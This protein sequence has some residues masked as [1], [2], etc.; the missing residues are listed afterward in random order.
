VGVVLLY[1]VA[2]AITLGG[3]G[4]LTIRQLLGVHTRFLMSGGTATIPAETSALVI[5]LLHAL[6]G[7]LIG[8]GVASLALTHFAA[9][10]GERWAAWTI[11]VIIVASEGMN[12]V[13]MYATGSFWYV[14]IAY[15]AIALAGA[16]LVLSAKRG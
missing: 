3:I 6:G 15:I 12:A 9:R 10:K 4:D 11:L 14:S 16:A 5:N 13:G 7:G 1:V 2:A 8:I